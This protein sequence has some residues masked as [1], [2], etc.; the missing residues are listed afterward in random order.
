MIHIS[1]YMYILA[2]E[3]YIVAPEMYILTPKMYILAPEMDKSLPYSPSD[4]FCNLN[5]PFTY[6]IFNKL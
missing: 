1:A 3:M 4:S 6:N 2:I 5:M